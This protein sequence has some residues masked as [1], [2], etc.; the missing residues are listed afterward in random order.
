MKI[1]FYDKRTE[2]TITEGYHFVDGNG[3]VYKDNGW[4]TESQEATVDFDHFVELCPN[5]GWEAYQE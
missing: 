1:R 5:I 2:E 4:Y 3:D